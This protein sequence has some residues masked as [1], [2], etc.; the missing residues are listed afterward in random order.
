VARFATSQ[1][2]KQRSPK[3]PGK[4]KEKAGWPLILLGTNEVNPKSLISNPKI[5]VKP[6]LSLSTRSGQ[7]SLLSLQ[8]LEGP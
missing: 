7:S 4:S 3:L 5:K 1:G 8:V 6:K 2:L